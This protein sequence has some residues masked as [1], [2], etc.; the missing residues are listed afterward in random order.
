[1][2]IYHRGNIFLNGYSCCNR[3]LKT[4]TQWRIQPNDDNINDGAKIKLTQNSS[5]KLIVED[6]A[7]REKRHVSNLLYAAYE[8]IIYVLVRCQGC[9]A[10]NDN[11]HNIRNP[12]SYMP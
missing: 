10:N 8:G 12:R 7:H 11:V 2:G 4:L 9:H 6:N 1:M 3:T 5:Q